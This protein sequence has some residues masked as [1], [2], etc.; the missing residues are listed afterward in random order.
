MYSYIKNN[1]LLT[2]ILYN[3][4]NIKHF[5]R[6]FVYIHLVIIKIMNLNKLNEFFS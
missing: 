5:Y 1:Y 2:L 4:K 3:A 6:I